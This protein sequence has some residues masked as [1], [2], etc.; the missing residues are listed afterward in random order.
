MK[1]SSIILQTSYISHTSFELTFNKLTP[2]CGTEP[3]GLYA[4]PV[5]LDDGRCPA[6]FHTVASSA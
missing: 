4:Q 5:A 6:V 1:T 3:T 2:N